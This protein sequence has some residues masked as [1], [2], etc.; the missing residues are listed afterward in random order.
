[1]AEE[2]DASA[3]HDR[4]KAVEDRQTELEVRLRKRERIQLVIN[5]LLFVL[6]VVALVGAWIALKVIAEILQD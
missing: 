4:L 5:M 2:S 1:V 3:F 6:I